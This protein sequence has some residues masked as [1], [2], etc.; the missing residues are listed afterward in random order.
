MAVRVYG[1]GSDFGDYDLLIS[2]DCSGIEPDC[3]DDSVEAFE[4]FSNAVELTTPT[5]NRSAQ[6][7]GP[8]SDYYVFPTATE[9]CEVD[10]TLTHPNNIR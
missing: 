3:V 5:F 9:N 4:S 1:V 6:M 8:D 7:C 10:F 2:E